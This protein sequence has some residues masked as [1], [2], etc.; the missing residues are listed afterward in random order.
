MPL[1]ILVIAPTP[2]FQNR[3]CHL[4]IRGEALGLQKMGH[5]VLIATYKEGLDVPELSVFRNF[6]SFGRFGEG[7][8]HSFKKIPNTFFLFFKSLSLALKEK[9][10]VLYCH[11]HEGAL[12]GWFLKKIVFLLSLFQVKPLLIFDGQ[13]GLADEMSS[14]GMIKNSLIL[15]LVGQIEKIIF[16][17][18]DLIFLS[19]RNFFLKITQG[20]NQNNIFFLP[21]S[22][23]IFNREEKDQNKQ[24]TKQAKIE[25]LKR[26]KNDLSELKFKKLSNWIEKEKVIVCYTGS[27]NE[28]K[29]FPL[30]TENIIPNLKNNKKVKFLVGGGKTREKFSN[31]CFLKNLNENNLYDFLLLSDIAIDPKPKNTSEA[32]GKILNYMAAALPVVCFK[33]PNNRFFLEDNGY[34]VEK[35]D[36]FWQTI[37][38]LSLSKEERIENGQLN[39][40]R[41]KEN[42]TEEKIAREIENRIKESLI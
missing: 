39:L 33:Q 14:S 26:R 29:G 10:D 20:R 27:F 36:E 40:K 18:P 32:S 30:L 23:S 8:A 3:G 5:R 6:R 7:T 1:K 22:V 15:K 37:E 41:V 38:K 11:L 35:E 19:S 2:F 9:P 17:M 34:L 21:D 31:C 24:K 12:I 4:R 13:G 28:A 25:V 16:K 42:F